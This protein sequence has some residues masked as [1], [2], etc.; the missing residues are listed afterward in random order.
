MELRGYFTLRSIDPKNG[1]QTGEIHYRNELIA[2]NEPM[3]KA[4]SYQ[5]AALLVLNDELEEAVK[6]ANN[7]LSEMGYDTKLFSQPT[8]C[9]RIDEYG[10]VLS[11]D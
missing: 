1:S 2:E 4:K 5:V 9:R 6:K 10:N 8:D 3:T 11:L 7:R